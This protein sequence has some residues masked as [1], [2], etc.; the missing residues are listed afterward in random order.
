[1]KINKISLILT[2]GFVVILS[3]FF[4]GSTANSSVVIS[5]SKITGNILST[6]EASN[7]WGT[8]FTCCGKEA[9]PSWRECYTYYANYYKK[10]QEFFND[11]YCR[12]CLFE[13]GGCTD[14]VLQDCANYF[15][16]YLDDSWC[17]S[18][19]YAGY[20]WYNAHEHGCRANDSVI[21]W[22]GGSDCDEED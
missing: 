19:N 12:L 20:G 13:L 7:I 5:D 18:S 14:N 9:C 6:N 2:I 3:S 11:C 21:C 17:G 8:C 15:Y 1:M 16:Y 22:F 10:Y 4:L